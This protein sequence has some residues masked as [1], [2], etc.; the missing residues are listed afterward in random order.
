MCTP[1]TRLTFSGSIT[2]NGQTRTVSKQ[3]L[4]PA[5]V[6]NCVARSGDSPKVTTTAQKQHPQS[7]R[8]QCDGQHVPGHR[9]M[10]IDGR[11]FFV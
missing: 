10:Q 1:I 8:W 11:G 2:G 7:A 4:L 3:L 6:K 5:G 9:T